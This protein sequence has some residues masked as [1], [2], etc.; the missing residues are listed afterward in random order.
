MI[1]SR[2]HQFVISFI[3]ACLCTTAVGAE[4][5][6]AKTDLIFEINNKK[7]QAWLID[8]SRRGGR[9]PIRPTHVAV[10]HIRRPHED[11][12]SS[13]E[14]ILKIL[15]T[16]AGQSLSQQ[17]QKFLTASDALTWWGIVDVQNH[18]TVLVYAVSEE[19]AKKTV[20][21]YL[22]VPINNAKA[23]VQ[24][25]EEFLNEHKER[26]SEINKELPE[27]RKQAK[28]AES[29]YKE[30]KNA[31]YFSF[32]DGEAYE[33]AQ[34]TMLQMD[35]MLDVLEIE[36]AGIQEKLK[37][38]EKFRSTKSLGGHRLSDE[39]LDKLDQ[40][41][42]EQMIEL[43]SAEARKEATHRI[44]NREKAFLDFFSR[45][46]SLNT[47]LNQLTAKLNNSE[48]NLRTTERYLANPRPDMLPPKL[49]QNKVTIYP[50]RP[51]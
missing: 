3:L 41:L 44:R 42:V 33:K 45:W 30:I 31:R 16:S 50:V 32:E 13:H 26:I 9:G 2:K 1:R 28:A 49:Y 25:Y 4:L 17:Q 27:K 23:R 39:T 21:A 15:K 46:D 7:S 37:S 22:E 43:R 6:E 24:E 19:D 11:M 48:K 20:Q 35:N 36:L 47:E 34:K 40:M 18:D 51:E 5:N 29:K 8:R 12:P 38:I 10:F 14:G